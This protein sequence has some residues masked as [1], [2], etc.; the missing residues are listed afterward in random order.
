MTD[1][2]VVAAVN[3]LLARQADVEAKSAAALSTDLARAAFVRARAAQ[4]QVSAL[5]ILRA[6]GEPLPPGF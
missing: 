1:V 2:A 5:S 4:G 3:A 6:S